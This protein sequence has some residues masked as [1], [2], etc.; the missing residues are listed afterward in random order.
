MT[1][2]VVMG[3]CLAN[4]P[5]AFLVND[6]KWQRPNNAAVLRSDHFLRHFIHGE[7]VLPEFDSVLARIRW[8]QGME[9]EVR[10]LRECY[11]DQVGHLEVPLDQP[12][13]F[14]TLSTQRIDVV[15]MDN[16]HDTHV[17]MCLYKPKAGEAPH[18][19]P[20]C[21]SYCEN[22]RELTE[23]YE[24]GSPLEPQESV[25]NWCE[26]VKFVQEKQPQ[27]RIIFFAAHSFTFKDHDPERCRRAVE[28]Y[29]EFKPLAA[30]LGIDLVPPF[31]LPLD[32]TR[33]PE[34]R[35][36]FDMAVYRGMAGL[37]FLKVMAG[38]AI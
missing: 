29:S 37:I 19:L 15:L 21:L 26:I 38:G 3:S 31:E 12:G 4:M 17:P 10:W 34:D 23:Y 13:L 36:H 30:E 7:G 35:D 28:F 8:H 32:L 14:E 27:A 16:L 24:Y 22:E 9:Q 1:T 20:F 11:R 25:S 33:M 2:A 6:F 5:C 18:A